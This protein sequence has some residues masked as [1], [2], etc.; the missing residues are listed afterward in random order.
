MPAKEYDLVVIGAG[1]GGVAAADTAALL[2]KRVALIE[3]TATI[4]GAAVNTGT[5]PSK[6]LRET[7]LAISGVKARALIGVDVSV[8]RE[9]KVE[10]LLRHERVVTASE[11]HQMRTLLDRYGVTV[12]RGTGKFVD[13]NTVRVTH[14]SPP[15]GFTDL[16][17]SKIVVAIGSM[18]VR[19]AVFPFENPRVHDSDE[20]LYITSIPRSLAVIGGG[21]IGSEYACMFAALGVRVHL[22]DGRDTLLPF[23][24]PD[25]SEALKDAMER[26]GIVFWWKDQVDACTA[27]RTGEIELRLKSGKELAVDHVLVCAGR[28]SAAAA[29]AP[30]VAGFGLTPRGLIPVDEHFR[31]T[32]PNVYAVGDV[33]GFPAL[34]STSAEQG[35]VAACHAFGSHAKEALAQ[36]LPAGIYTIPEISAVGLT[37][38]QAREKGIPIV[39]GRADYDQNPRG[40]IIGD[41]LG[42]LKLVFAREDLKLLG[43]HV[44]GEQASELVHIGLIAMMTGGDANLFLATCFNYPTLGDLYKLATHD[45]ILKR[46]E[47]LGRSPASMSRW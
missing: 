10:D 31:T 24:D 5:I 30:E 38:A 47:L 9:A 7:A 25:L 4:G 8:R 2:G 36:F 37:E 21:V 46:N 16:W 6:T 41:K 32:N 33:I 28:T 22:I 27:P 13:P 23:L 11:S 17:A 39:V 15:G 35:R 1:P 34:A 20:L 40:K 26:Q 29:L 19:P 12:Y 44:I 45:A 42:F 18:P 14:P 43:V 3:R